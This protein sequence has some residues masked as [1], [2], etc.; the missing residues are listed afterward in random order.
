MKRHVIEND[1]TEPKSKR[2][3]LPKTTTAPIITKVVK[4]VDNIAEGKEFCIFNSTQ[5]TV[6]DLEDMVR[7]HGG[8]TVK[9][10]SDK[11]FVCIAATKSFRVLS[12][13]DEGKG[14]KKKE[15]YDIAKVEWLLKAMQSDTP[16]D[17][18]LPLHPSDMLHITDKLQQQFDQ[19]FDPYGDSYTKPV[20]EAELGRLLDSM[21]FEVNY[22][23]SKLSKFR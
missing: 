13:M 9:S 1:I 19:E 10:P 21:D 3:R 20:D 17:R 4:L 2:R 22:I 16:L 15:T 6:E 23:Q 18:L 7:K 5:P 12:Y 11:T 14:N 8:E